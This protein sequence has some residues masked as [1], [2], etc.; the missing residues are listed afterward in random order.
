MS[1]PFLAEIRMMSFNFPP[2]GWALCNGQFLPIN[3]NQAL[4][5]LLGTSYGGNGQTTFALPDLRG[6]VPVHS[7]PLTGPP[8][9]AGGREAVTLTQAEIP[10]HT[11]AL[12]ATTALATSGAP[13]GA[14]LGKKGRLGR[15]VF[16]A[17]ANLV[18]L[19]PD[20]VTSTGG[21]QPHNNMQPYLTI[22]FAIALQG[23]F[24]SP[25]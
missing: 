8:G 10:A 13:A 9:A 3:Q 2:K 11:H 1:E 14:L 21:S 18:A 4:F 23:I 12:H 19:N 20:A 24:P 7:G 5:A 16:A 17:P 15:D 25:N 22:N 6:R